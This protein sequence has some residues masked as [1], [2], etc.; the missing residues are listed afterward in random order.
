MMEAITRHDAITISEAADAIRVSRRHLQTLL[1][2][3]DG[4]PV[5][6]LGR[7]MI[8]RSEALRQWLAER[9]SL[10]ASAH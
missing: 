6:R 5:V 7:R 10:H 9:E 1:K 8:I 4:P 3:G 2:K